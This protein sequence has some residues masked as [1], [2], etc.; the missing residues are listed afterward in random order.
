MSKKK[1]G[2]TKQE[3]NKEIKKAK[4]TAKYRAKDLGRMLALWQS[5]ERPLE[6]AINSHGDV[7]FLEENY[8]LVA[9]YD[10]KGKEV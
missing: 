7:R 10:E 4:A 8:T 6:L 3:I 1:K 9:I 5:K 2:P